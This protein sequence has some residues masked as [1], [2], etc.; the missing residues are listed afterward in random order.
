MANYLFDFEM[1]ML[2]RIASLLIVCLVAACGGSGDG[3]TSLYGGGTTTTAT[4]ADLILTVSAASMPNTASATVAVTVTALDASRNTLAAMPVSLSSDNGSVLGTVSGAKTGTDGTVTATLSAG[5]DQANRLIT[6]TAVS[7]GVSKTA[8]VQVSGTTVSATLVPAVVSPNAAGQIQYKVVDKVGTAMASQVVDI[9]STGLTPTSATG[10]TDTTGAFTYSYTAPAATGSYDVTINVGGVSNTQTVVVQP[11][12]TVPNVTATIASAS[13]S[14]NP[15]VVAVNTAGSTANQSSI[16]ALF[17]GTNNLPIANVRA[18]FDLNG[19]ANSIGGTF[20]TGATTLYSDAN[21]VVTTSYVPGSRSSPTDGVAV[22]LC[23][24]I[25]DSDPNFTGCLTYKLVTLTVSAEPLG[26][27]IGTNALIIVKTLTYVK[28][29]V[30]TVVDSAGNPKADV[31]IVA[32]IDLPNY[33]KGHYTSGTTWAKAG[34]LASGDAAICANEDQNRNGVLDG[35]DDTT[36]NGLT[37]NGDGQLWPRKPDVTVSLLNASGTQ[38]TSTTTGANGTAI[39]QIE[40]AQDHGSWVDALITVAASG[41]SGS[42]GR[43]S[44]LIA[45]VPVPITDL[46]NVAQP[47]AYV[48]S[49]YGTGS[50]CKSPL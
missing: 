42:E 32:S 16:R 38:V 15:S 28:Q 43:A 23:Y 2:K 4:T 6:I 1:T 46:T 14:A 40:Y 5:G 10:V 24:G 34:A 41:V 19:D 30:V 21:G 8:T 29:Y 35:D 25:S 36:N 49:P 20:T 31:T 44:Y 26:V 13:V 12:N 37:G 3:G 7:G 48:V 47:P 50:L 33:R 39:L 18:K 17:L 27:T 45:P 9:T 22:R 11:V